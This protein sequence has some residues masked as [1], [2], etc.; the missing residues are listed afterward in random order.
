MITEL[1][2]LLLD[3]LKE[4]FDG[5]AV[6]VEDYPNDPEGYVLRAEAAVLVRFVGV[7]YSDTD[8]SETVRQVGQVQF[9]VVTVARNKRTHTGCYQVLDSVRHEV[10]GIR[11]REQPFA[12]VSE[13]LIGESS[14][15]WYY[16][17]V[18]GIRQRVRQS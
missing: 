3:E 6:A 2:E 10:L 17:Q 4:Y 18:F 1:S 8:S 7:T 9:Q 13:E 14:G 16:S 5:S 15:V 12:A 11:Y